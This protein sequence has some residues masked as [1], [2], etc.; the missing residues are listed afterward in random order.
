MAAT[1][2][3]QTA[4]RSLWGA[5]RAADARRGRT[6]GF[7]D[8][9]AAVA[10]KSEIVVTSGDADECRYASGEEGHDTMAYSQGICQVEFVRGAPFT[11]SISP[12]S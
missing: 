12:S 6:G 10:E 1:S 5:K 2:T 9:A 8:H 11:I 3:K 7:A 4:K